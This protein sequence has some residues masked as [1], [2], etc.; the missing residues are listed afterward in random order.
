MRQR[1]SSHCAGRGADRF[2]YIIPQVMRPRWC[3]RGDCWDVMLLCATMRWNY[4]TCIHVF[5]QAASY[6]GAMGACSS[7]LQGHP[8]HIATLTYRTNIIRV[9]LFCCCHSWQTSP[10]QKHKFILS[11]DCFPTGTSRLRSNLPPVGKSH[12]LPPFMDFTK[13]SPDALLMFM[14]RLSIHF[15]SVK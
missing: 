6:S 12:S 7:C 15:K 14:Q 2:A 1:V 11:F 5:L 8:G 13:M 4:Q 10:W 3:Y 9:G